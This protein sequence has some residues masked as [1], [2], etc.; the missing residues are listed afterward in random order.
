MGTAAPGQ[1]SIK[2]SSGPNCHSMADVK[3][4]AEILLSHYGLEFEPTAVPMDWK[5]IPAKTGKLCFGLMT[6]DGVVEPQPPIARALE[7]TAAKL[8]EAGHEGT[9]AH[10]SR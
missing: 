9:A 3:L 8:R 10:K 6:T 2:V 4:V 1:I 7:N 5:Q